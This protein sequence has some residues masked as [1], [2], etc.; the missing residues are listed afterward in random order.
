MDTSIQQYF[1]QSDTP[2]A[3]SPV[4]LL[5]V[6]VLAKFP[7]LSFDAAR[8][9]ARRLLNAAASSFHFTTPRVLSSEQ[10]QAA[11]DRLQSFKDSHKKPPVAQQEELLGVVSNTEAA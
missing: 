9:E 2:S 8:T 5:M 4:G 3:G 10:R 7:E 1:A 11:K 6:R